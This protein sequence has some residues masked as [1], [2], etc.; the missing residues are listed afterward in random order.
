M[1][2]DVGQCDGIM[3]GDAPRTKK[4]CYG[5]QFSSHGKK[6]RVFFL[7]FSYRYRE[8]RLQRNNGSSSQ[9]SLTGE[10]SEAG[11]YGTVPGSKK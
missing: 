7:R 9:D 5:I 4:Q 10:R 1:L 11:L 3:N 8:R 2:S 6:T